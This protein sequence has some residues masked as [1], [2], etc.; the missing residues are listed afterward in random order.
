M[1]VLSDSLRPPDCSPPDSS[2]LGDSPGEKMSGLPFPPPGDLPDP[3][4]KPA[5]PALASVFFT[6][7]PPREPFHAHK[8]LN[9]FSVNYTELKK[10]TQRGDMLHNCIYVTYLVEKISSNTD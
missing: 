7:E 9:E 3:R 10:P 8:K 6:P 1:S 2:I 5:S 4:I